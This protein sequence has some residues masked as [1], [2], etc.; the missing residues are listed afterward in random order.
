MQGVSRIA[1]SARIRRGTARRAPTFEYDVRSLPLD[2][3]YSWHMVFHLA[4]FDE[5]LDYVDVNDAVFRCIAEEIRRLLPAKIRLDG[6]APE[7]PHLD[8]AAV[9]VAQVLARAIDDRA[10]PYLRRGVLAVDRRHVVL[11]ARAAH[12]WRGTRT[13][14]L[15]FAPRL[16]VVFRMN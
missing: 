9:G 4:S 3:D 6:L 2:M 1:R 8:D 16:A 5:L 10:L 13:L 14:G 7:L 15:L 12:E 11:F